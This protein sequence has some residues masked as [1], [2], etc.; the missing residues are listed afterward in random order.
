MPFTR[1]GIQKAESR[2]PDGAQRNPG[3][4]RRRLNRRAA[5]RPQK[6]LQIEVHPLLPPG[7]QFGLARA[8]P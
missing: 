5:S 7:A 3:D 1:H 2:S 4:G 6:S 8:L